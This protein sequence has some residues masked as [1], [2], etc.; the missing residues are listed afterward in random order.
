[1]ED[2]KLKGNKKRVDEMDGIL[3][4]NFALKSEL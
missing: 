4:E 2:E 3:Q 1:M